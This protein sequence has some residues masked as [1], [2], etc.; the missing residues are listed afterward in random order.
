[1]RVAGAVA[2]FV[3]AA[4]VSAFAQPV[5]KPIPVTVTLVNLTVADIFHTITKMTGVAIQVDS[6]IALEVD[7]RKIPHLSFEKAP[8]ADVLGFVSRANEWT[9]EVIDEMTV[10]IHRPQQG[11]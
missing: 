5:L 8:V 7:A 3:L 6:A 2:A 9:V 10:R 11:Q 1:M 4:V